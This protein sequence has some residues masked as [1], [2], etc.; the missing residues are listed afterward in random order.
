MTAPRPPLLSLDEAL[1][2][3][4]QVAAAHT[5]G[6]IEVVSSLDALGRVLAAEVRSTIDVPAI[7][8][9]SAQD[10]RLARCDQTP[11]ARS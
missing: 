5:I 2:R 8:A 9:S 10:C 4:L 6:Q 3:L 7:F 1:A 11:C